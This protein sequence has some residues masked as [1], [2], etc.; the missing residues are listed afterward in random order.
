MKRTIILLLLILSVL[1]TACASE[2]EKTEAQPQSTAESETVETKS[3]EEPMKTSYEVQE[4][5]D[6]LAQWSVEASFPA[7]P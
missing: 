5:T 7:A 2:D 6:D 4:G 1:F 3:D